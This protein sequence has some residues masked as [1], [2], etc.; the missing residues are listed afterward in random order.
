MDGA[1]ASLRLK[2]AVTMPASTVLGARM[3][4]SAAVEGERGWV[5]PSADARGARR[6]RGVHD[7]RQTRSPSQGPGV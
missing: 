6:R 3:P 4:I 7:Q 2:Q 1:S 5:S